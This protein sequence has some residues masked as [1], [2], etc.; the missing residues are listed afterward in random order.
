MDSDPFDV[1]S[2]LH[3]LWGQEALA[4]DAG[5]LHV[6]STWPRGDARHVIRITEQSPKSDT[7]F[8]LL[9]L[10][11]ARADV[12]VTTGRI[13]REEPH[14]DYSLP[15]AWAP[16]MLAWRK[17]AM[18]RADPP[19]V[20]VLTSGRDLDLD[21]PAFHGWAR[22]VVLTSQD[23][24]RALRPRVPGHIDVIGLKLPSPREAIAWARALGATTIS[25]EAGP[26]TARA[27]YADPVLVDELW[28][29]EFLESDLPHALRGPVVFE[30]MPGGGALAPI[31]A[32]AL[33]HEVSGQWRYSRFG[34]REAS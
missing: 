24:A 13:L 6:V 3:G 15:A 33:R 21:H 26:S 23:A 9:N 31:G 30:G 19:K 25:I 18:R 2:M 27:L 11:R 29:S 1:E 17:A 4:R 7:D 32:R 22:P 14:L 10:A 16:G 8:F 12:I 28:L 20:A 5:V 34:R